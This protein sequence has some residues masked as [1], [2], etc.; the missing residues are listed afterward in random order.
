MENGEK[1]K[2]ELRT[3]SKLSRRALGNNAGPHTH[4]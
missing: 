3:R 4:T 2:N 1:I